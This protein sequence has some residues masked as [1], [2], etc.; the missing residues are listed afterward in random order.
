MVG[1]NSLNR[2]PGKR[3]LWV[4]KRTLPTYIGVIGRRTPRE[5]GH[6]GPTTQLGRNHT[7][8]SDGTDMSNSTPTKRETE[9]AFDRL[10]SVSKNLALLMRRLS[11]VKEKQQLATRTGT[12]VSETEIEHPQTQALEL[13]ALVQSQLESVER[14]LKA[15]SDPFPVFSGLSSDDGEDVSR[16]DGD[17]PDDSRARPDVVDRWRQWGKRDENPHEKPIECDYPGT[18]CDGVNFRTLEVLTEH[19]ER[20]HRGE[21]ANPSER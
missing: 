16:F 3:I 5:G 6:L 1:K 19:R 4:G 7:P 11:E 17:W 12:G 13:L 8:V 18:G 2:S 9:E 15:E 14:D 20:D 10:C 21:E